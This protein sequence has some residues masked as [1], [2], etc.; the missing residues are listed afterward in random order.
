MSIESVSVAV[1]IGGLFQPGHLEVADAPPRLYRFS[2]QEYQRMREAG[3]FEPNARVELLEGMIVQKSPIGSPH[4]YTTR[5]QVF[6]EQQQVPLVL[7]SK[8][9]ALIAV[10]DLLP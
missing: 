8:T 6:E 1:P 5:H 7:D 9:I 2:R 10:H 4:A 3:V